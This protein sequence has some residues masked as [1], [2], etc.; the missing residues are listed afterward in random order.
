MVP[1]KNF[2]TFGNASVS[3]VTSIS[4]GSLDFFSFLGF[5][6]DP[7]IKLEN[8]ADPRILLFDWL[9]I[10]CHT[11]GGSI[12]SPICKTNPLPNSKIMSYTP[13]LLAIH[14]HHSPPISPITHPYHPFLNTTYHSKQEGSK[15]TSKNLPLVGAINLPLPKAVPHVKIF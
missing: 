6:N 15:H 12:A 5:P 14:I 11:I 1:F 13:A 4:T 3:L 7:S 10:L 9:S 8:I 2:S